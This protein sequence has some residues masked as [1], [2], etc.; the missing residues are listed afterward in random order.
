MDEFKRAPDVDCHVV[1]AGGARFN[2]E[3][4]LRTNL[5]GTIECLLAENRKIVSIVPSKIGANTITEYIVLS[6]KP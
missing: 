3:K 6:H 4:E 5:T 2:Q 1:D